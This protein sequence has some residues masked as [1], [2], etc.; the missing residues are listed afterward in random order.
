MRLVT[1]VFGF[2]FVTILSM[3]FY[4]Y[5]KEQKLDPNPGERNG[6]I[7]TDI[8]QFAEY[9]T[10]LKAIATTTEVNFES[11]PEAKIFKTAIKEWFARGPQ[12]GGVYAVAEWSCGA[13][14]QEHAIIDVRDGTITKYGLLGT[15]GVAYRTDSNLLVVNPPWNIESEVSR[16][17]TATAEFYKLQDGE[18]RLLCKKV[19]PPK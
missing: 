2:G 12:L 18:P 15:Y 11:L 7:C 3:F 10:D 8:P 9:R 19:Y 1:I 6:G 4:S 5:F 16:F 13:L 14:C 17:A